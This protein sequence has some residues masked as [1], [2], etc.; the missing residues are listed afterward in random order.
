MKRQLV[1]V[2]EK[3]INVEK[4]VDIM[5]QILQLKTNE[6]KK[7]SKKINVPA[8]IAQSRRDGYQQGITEKDFIWKIKNE[9][10]SILK[11]NSAENKEKSGFIIEFV[12]GQYPEEVEGVIREGI[13]TNFESIKAKKRREETGKQEEHNKKMAVYSRM[14]RS[15]R[16][17][18]DANRKRKKYIFMSDVSISSS[19]TT[20]VKPADLD[21]NQKRWLFVGICLHSVI[22]PALR[23][24]I[25]PILTK[26]FH[27]LSI[28]YRIDTQ[29]YPK[30]LQKYPTTNAFLNYE[31]ANNNKA[32]YGN[33]RAKYDY[34][35]KNAVD[36]SK[37]F[38]LT[39]MTHY[40]GFDEKCD[41]SALLGL[42]IN[43][44]QF[45][46]VVKSVAE[47]VRRDV[48]NPWAHCDFTEWD[49]IKYATSFQLMEKLVK[50]LSLSS[51]DENQIVVEIN[52]WKENGQRFL[53]GTTFGLELVNEIRQQTQSLAEYSKHVVTTTDNNFLKMKKELDNCEKVFENKV[54]NLKKNNEREFC[55]LKEVSKHFSVT[56]H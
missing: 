34:A 55:E 14:R 2:Q 16:N 28:Q 36:L 37:L 30:Y 11:Y 53:S 31:A 6:P 25:V 13:K 19:T 42:I 21:D 49:A 33:Q 38:I 4:K 20:S 3:Q 40:T 24:Y 52:K 12:K 9:T 18:I 45:P 15:S 46:P 8:Q 10:G 48:R 29:T 5:I 50:D 54:N 1:K 44:D 41:S 39:H 47:N 7:G 23:K 32:V 43:I 22:S 26:L 56:I 27:K 51:I 17:Q 35:I